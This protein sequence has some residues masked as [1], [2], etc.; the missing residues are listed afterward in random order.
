[1]KLRLDQI[2]V[3]REKITTYLL[4]PKPKNDKS[5]FLKKLGYSINDAEELIKDIKELAI[6]NEV[7][8]SRT[9]EFGDLYTVSGK[10]KNKLVVTVWLE[11]V[12]DDTFRFI[13]L[14][15]V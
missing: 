2:I 14:Y 15:P 12:D 11:Q 5:S 6:E 8:L 9:S 4:V 3:S 13:T 1:M 10:L 7:K